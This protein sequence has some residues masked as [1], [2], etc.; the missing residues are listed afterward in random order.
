MFRG[1]FIS[2]YL[3]IVVL[4]SVFFFV[5]LHVL[6]EYLGVLLDDILCQVHDLACSSR[7]LWV[8]LLV[9]LQDI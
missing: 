5:S 8:V 2:F 7:G 3:K 4:A 6:R 9:V 1:V